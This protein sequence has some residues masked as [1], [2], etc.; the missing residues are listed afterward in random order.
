MS[1]QPAFPRLSAECPKLLRPDPGVVLLS[2]GDARMSESPRYGLD[3]R[4]SILQLLSHIPCESFSLQVQLP[5]G[6]AKVRDFLPQFILRSLPRIPNPDYALI[7]LSRQ[8][9]AAE[10]TTK[11]RH[12]LASDGDRARCH[13]LRM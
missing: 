2:R 1:R 7:G 8:D 11:N 4:T 13:R 12:L 6:L 5:L 10:R 9:G 3:W